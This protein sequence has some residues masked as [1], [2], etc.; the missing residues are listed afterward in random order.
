MLFQQLPGETDAITP[1][2]VV[3]GGIGTC[4]T[5]AGLG[6]IASV[7]PETI[8]DAV[9]DNGDGTYTV[10]FHEQ[11]MPGMIWDR[12]WTTHEVTVDA[13]APVDESGNLLSAQAPYGETWPLI[14]EKAWAEYN[15]GYHRINGDSGSALLEAVTG[16]TASFHESIVDAAADQLPGSSPVLPSLETLG[17]WHDSGRAIITGVHNHMLYILDVDVES[18]TL[19]IGNPWGAQY[20]RTISYDEWKNG[21]EF[22]SLSVV[23]TDATDD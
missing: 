4:V 18:G 2:D 13:R 10:T 22:R 19:T 21:G 8:R 14:I 6:A 11:R 20:T 15:G 7:S 16:H 5:L 1:T 17:R 23:S 3:Q 12:E 9:R